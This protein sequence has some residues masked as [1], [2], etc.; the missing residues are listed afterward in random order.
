MSLDLIILSGQ[1]CLVTSLTG[2]L[3]GSLL[4]CGDSLSVSSC[5]LSG[6]QSLCLLLLS[7][8]VPLC[9]PCPVCSPSLVELPDPDLLGVMLG[10]NHVVV[11]RYLLPKVPEAPVGDLD[12]VSVEQGMEDVTGRDGGVEDLEELGPDT[13][14]YPGIPRR[15]K[16]PDLPLPAPGFSFFIL[17]IERVDVL[18]L[19]FKVKRVAT[20]LEGFLIFRLAFVEHFLI[21]RQ[22]IK[23]IIDISWNILYNGRRVIRQSIDIDGV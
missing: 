11:D 14:G 22:N 20:G 12:R 13:A 5:C 19:I 4:G 23:A 16:P 21:T 3:T 17:V 2:S 1:G 8:P 15:I 7:G 18:L 10:V 9:L 6:R